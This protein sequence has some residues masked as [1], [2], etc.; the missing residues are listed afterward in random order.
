MKRNYFAA[1]H[2]LSYVISLRKRRVNQR[3]DLLLN[4]IQSSPK[5]KVFSSIVTN[6]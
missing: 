3:G 1:R 5:F 6:Q 4:L 2:C